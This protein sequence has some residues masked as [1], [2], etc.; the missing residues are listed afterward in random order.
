MA[1]LW[2]MRHAETDFNRYNL[3]MGRTDH[4]L[5]ENGLEQARRAG[6]AM[7]VVKLA[8]I[9]ASPL[10]RARQTAQI[11]AASQSE[12]PPV[13]LLDG[14]VERRFGTF[15]GLVKTENRRK[16]MESDPTVEALEVVVARL[17]QAVDAIDVSGPVLIVSHS[18][19]FQCLVK[20]L[21]FTPKP[22]RTRIGNAEVVEL[23]RRPEPFNAGRHC[24]MT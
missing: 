10:L 8:F 6:M 3:W 11:V 15:E 16:L 4:G 13:V 17:Q 18:A 23:S 19:V 24:T 20:Q 5:N 9:Y 12:P 2:F 7:S 1:S 14:L 21:G 22:C